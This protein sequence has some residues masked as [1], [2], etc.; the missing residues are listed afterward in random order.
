[1]V[2]SHQYSKAHWVLSLIPELLHSYKKKVLNN[3]YTEDSKW[4]LHPTAKLL[5]RYIIS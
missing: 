1:M 3:V 5:K 4:M 2:V